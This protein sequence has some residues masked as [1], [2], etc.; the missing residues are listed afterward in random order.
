MA[1][2]RGCSRR[3]ARSN[4]EIEK[5]AQRSTSASSAAADEEPAAPWKALFFFT[6]KANLPTL[7][8]GLVA[9]LVAGAIQPLSAFIQGKLFEGFTDF[10]TGK[11][12]SAALYSQSRKW[13]L[14]YV[15]LAVVSWLGNFAV[16][17][18][19]LAFGELQ[20]KSARDRLFHGLLEKDIRW[21]DMRKNGIG[22]LL[23]RLQAQIRDLQL[24]TS[25]P[26]GELFQLVVTAML[27]LG[28][29]FYFGWDLTLVT[30]STVPII[31]GLVF[32]VGA[33]MQG[34]IA[35]QQARLTEAQKCSNS[36]FGAVETVK[37]F[38]GQVIELRKY[39]AKVSEAALS[40]YK[41]AN[42]ASIQT[43]LIVFLSSTIFVQGFY[44]GGVLVDKQ[45]KTPAEIM[46]CFLAAVAAFQAIQSLI[47]Q[48]VVLEKGRAAGATLRR[49]MAE[50]IGGLKTEHTDS[51]LRPAICRGD[52]DVKNV[53]FAYPSR[54]GQLAL[55]NVS[56][57]IQGGEMTFLIGK[58]G[59]GKSTISQLLM[60]FHDAGE[61]CITVD[62]VPLA[63]LDA[64]WLRSNLTLVEQTTL[65]F[66]DTVF[67]NIAFGRH[68]YKSV[69]K[70]EVMAAAEFALLQLM[71]TDMSE[72]LD[73]LVGHK[74]GAMSGGQR[75][76]MALARAR[77]RDTPVLM[78]DESTSALDHI[79]RALMMD[80][81][82]QWRKGKTTIIITHDISQIEADDYVYVLE[83]G[84]VAQEGYRKHM[85][86][87]PDSPFQGFLPPSRRV[88]A[89]PN[90]SRKNTTFESI[91]TR[92]S[93]MD[94]SS[95]YSR[96]VDDTFADPLHEQLK[97]SERKKNNRKTWMPSV[98]IEGSPAPNIRGMGGLGKKSAFT[99]PFLRMPVAST[100][101]PKLTTAWEPVPPGKPR[102]IS[103]D[104]TLVVSPKSN[105][106][107]GRV[108]ARMS[109]L[110]E[111]LVN[112]AGNAAADARAGPDN[113]LRRRR[114][115]VDEVALAK[116]TGEGL[117]KLDE[118][119]EAQPGDAVVQMGSK[120]ILKTLWPNL[121]L[122]A[123]INIVFGFYC[124]TIH[125]VATPVFS[126]VFAK[127]LV[128][129]SDP[130]DRVHK[131]LVYSMTMLAIAAADGIH[132]Y[133]FRLCLEYAG[134][135]WVDSLRSEAMARIL[136]QPRAFFDK[137]IN[138]VSRMTEGL[139]RNAE[140][141]RNLLGRFIGMMYV[142]AL[143]VTV[144]LIWAISAQWK[145]SLICLA[146]A[147]PY[148]FVVTNAFAGVS[149][150]W[151]SLSNDAA[152][153]ASAIF[154]ETFTNIKT[155][156]AF[157][158]EDHFK[159]KYELATN[160]TLKVGFI[161]AF[162]SGFFFGLSDSASTFVT[163]LIFYIATIIARDG[164]PSLIPSIIQV[165]A[166]LIF[167]ITNVSAILGY[168]PQIG[169][170]K[171]TASRLLR[172]AQLPKSSHEHLGD[173][174]I[175]TVGDIVFTGL[176]FS[177]PSRPD[178]TIL[179]NINLRIKPGASVA[180]VGGSGSGKSTIA[181]LLLNLYC[182]SSPPS[183]RGSRKLGDLTLAG[184]DIKH[185]YTPSLR[186]LVVVVSQSPAIFAATVEEN[187]LYGLPSDSPYTRRTNIVDA[188]RAAG[189]H[190]FITSL[191]S[192]YNTLIGDGGM[193][194]SG[195]QAQRIAIARALVRNPA[196]L[197]LDEA[198]SALD[199]ESATLIRQTLQRLLQER[200]GRI[201]VI[202]ITHS[203]EQME[204]AER[205]VVLDQGRI[206]E[207]GTFGELME[208]KGALRNLLN[209]GEWEGGDED[210]GDER[211][212][213]DAEI[214]SEARRRGQRESS[215]EDYD[216]EGKSRTRPRQRT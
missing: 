193:G 148:V 196:V 9:A 206:V 154:T 183:S 132:T 73:T 127:L 56:M 107:S 86:T 212:A 40:Y 99:A 204:I 213:R 172:L 96:E 25:Q 116:L 140:E 43:G 141:M 85:E 109:T 121:D 97:A 199:V 139:D 110:M 119:E 138:S 134:Q 126:Y 72:G 201:T 50:V 179:R 45:K 215:L 130:T 77:L 44:Y 124:G 12:T 66:N 157:T 5:P 216:W 80:A 31:M 74:G 32:W 198:T 17:A 105:R 181:N 4:R 13:I 158:L 48:L 47:P 68:D 98:F 189:I 114:K 108:S 82:R 151:E 186:A 194:V 11:L 81:I 211:V 167:T 143:M 205:I 39:A 214:E 89:R 20:A 160:Y 8:I 174:R 33:G 129:L 142:A 55:E 52:I 146:A 120:S 54:P 60:R 112:R 76:R 49:V 165:L 155:V 164:G 34:A 18:T 147:A 122:I 37:C 28:E 24:A 153:S 42:L 65:L 169:A 136:D 3:R 51:L 104:M 182:T 79:S 101:M 10:A 159:E 144:S 94:S 27:S 53:S 29:A 58:S 2:H 150:R 117:A 21:Y 26:L 59:S 170:A 188:A 187:I 178:Q 95:I 163:A 16:F 168:L 14:Y 30:I 118:D 41:V 69:S 83:H 23:P 208:R 90:V 62:G 7:V 22:A 91:H 145:F 125:A 171:D 131:S 202:I 71:I 152:E 67:R 115:M 166:I 209:G 93:S 197:V 176:K 161:R 200:R 70:A 84:K 149:G 75:Q 78:L 38:N 106:K 61:G 111:G 207:D 185:I 123:R 210:A 35:T 190:D 6:T 135:R 195:G 88:R 173:T 184:R 102:P 113:G 64:K 177:Y 46:T 180:I 191:P 128:T 36:A 15:G 57:Y 92:S 133:A 192:G 63:S 19:W 137:E 100:F 156:R 175:N 103:S 1:N 87:I 203:R 162:R